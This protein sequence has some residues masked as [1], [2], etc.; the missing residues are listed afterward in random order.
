[1]RELGAINALKTMEE[2]GAL[3]DLPYK[4]DNNADFLLTKG[5]PVFPTW[6]FANQH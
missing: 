6:V 1:M 5:F 3:I 4:W 2:P